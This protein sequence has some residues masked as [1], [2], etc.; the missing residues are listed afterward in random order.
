ME[1]IFLLQLTFVVICKLGL[2]LVNFT[3]VFLRW[4]EYSNFH[5]WQLCLGHSC[6]I[7]NVDR[8]PT[9]RFEV[10]KVV[11]KLVPL[12]LIYCNYISVVASNKNTSEIRTFIHAHLRTL[13]YLSN[14]LIAN[15]LKLL[16]SCN[17]YL[18]IG[19]FLGN[20]IA[21]NFS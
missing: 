9:I 18:H 10:W 5:I 13:F 1:D 7:C 17:L 6:L 11:A 15:F 12:K 2:K 4:L 8:Q 14:Q 20:E 21:L 3:D 16:S 19:I